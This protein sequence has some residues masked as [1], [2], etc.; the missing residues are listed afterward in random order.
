MHPFAA[1]TAALILAASLP[2]YAQEEVDPLPHT[3]QE[4][5]RAS[6]DQPKT[7]LQVRVSNYASKVK[8]CESPQAFL[9]HKVS[10]SGRVTV[11]LRCLGREQQPLYLTADVKLFGRYWVPTTDIAR[12]AVITPLMLSEH[13]GDLSKLP[14]DVLQDPQQIIGKQ[15]NRALKTGKPVQKSALQAVYLVK[16]NATVDVQAIGVG[17]LI[18]RDGMAMDDGALGDLVRVK[19]KGGDMVKATVTGQNVLNIDI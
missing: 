8:D 12:G 16:R 5:I 17:F 18:K 9:P 11:G 3:I 15:T 10:G 19:L 6:L 14:R 4:L 2:S 13:N 7:L 1:V